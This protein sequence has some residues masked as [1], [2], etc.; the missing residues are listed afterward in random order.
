MFDVS[1][2]GGSTAAGGDERMHGGQGRGPFRGSGATL[3]ARVKRS[4]PQGANTK[5]VY[6]DGRDMHAILG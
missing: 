4:A 3:A 2:L 5:V 6:F 1:V